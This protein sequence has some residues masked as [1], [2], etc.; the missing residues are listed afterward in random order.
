MKVY[1]VQFRPS[2]KCDLRNIYLYINKQASANIAKSYITRIHS[3]AVKLNL[4]PYRGS[5]IS[6]PHITNL[7]VVGFEH[8]VSILFCIREEEIAILRILYG[9]RNMQKILESLQP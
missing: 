3:F 1:S 6:H 8:R 9:G 7:R 4:A 2:A 5:S